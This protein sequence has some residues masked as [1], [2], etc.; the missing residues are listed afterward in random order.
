MIVGVP[1]KYQTEYS[2]NIN[3]E[4]KWSKRDSLA[5]LVRLVTCS[6]RQRCCLLDC[7]S[8]NLPTWPTT[9]GLQIYHYTI[10]LVHSLWDRTR[11]FEEK[12]DCVNTTK[13]KQNHFYVCSVVKWNV[14]VNRVWYS[15]NETELRPQPLGSNLVRSTSWK[16]SEIML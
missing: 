1:V 13:M 7:G 15:S 8:S 5:P 9:R 2:P 12:S 6:V 10:Q 16:M 4:H 11:G 3:L 14:C